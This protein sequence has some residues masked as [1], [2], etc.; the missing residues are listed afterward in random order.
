MPVADVEL[1]RGRAVTGKRLPPAGGWESA[2]AGHAGVQSSNEDHTS[3]RNVGTKPLYFLGNACPP[4]ER[5]LTVRT[6]LASIT[7]SFLIGVAGA[8][9]VPSPY[10]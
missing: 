5:G 7:V 3:R 8:F 6:K 1:A 4:N 2:K 9:A 10:A